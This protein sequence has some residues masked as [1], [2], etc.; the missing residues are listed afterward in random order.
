MHKKTEHK[1]VV[2]RTKHQGQYAERIKGDKMF[3][4]D[5]RARITDKRGA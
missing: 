5:A 2:V 4:L 3:R 1:A